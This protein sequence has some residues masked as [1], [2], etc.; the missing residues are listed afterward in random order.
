[1]SPGESN[2]VNYSESD[3]NITSTSSTSEEVI[4]PLL[5]NPRRIV[6][7]H[8][9]SGKAIISMDDEVEVMDQWQG[10]IR[11]AKIWTNQ[12]IPTKDNLTDVDGSTRP[13]PGLGLILPQG[14]SHRYTDLA[15]GRMT[16]MHRTNSVDYNILI[17]GQL[18][19]VLDNDVEKEVEVG[20]VVIQRGTRHGWRNP[21]TTEWTRWVSVLIDAVPVE[22]DGKPLE[23]T[24]EP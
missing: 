5:P 8:D 23:D 14:I 21:S 17:S 13:V 20:H 19:L 15:P 2:E 16:P 7:G 3:S 18:I 22:V 12:H 4:V 6:T 11:G 1:M 9:E 10:V 24:W